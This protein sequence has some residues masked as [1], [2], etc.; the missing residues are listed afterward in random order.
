MHFVQGR[1][2]VA[3]KVTKEG[4]FLC[5]DEK[6]LLTECGAVFASAK[7][8]CVNMLQMLIYLFQHTSRLFCKARRFDRVAP[9]IFK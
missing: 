1:T 7:D 3:D 2:G 8:D 4:N 5:T 9:A 6:L